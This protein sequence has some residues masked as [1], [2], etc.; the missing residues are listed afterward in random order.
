MQ[1]LNHIAK[2]GQQVFIEPDESTNGP[3]FSAEK[4]TTAIRDMLRGCGL[5]EDTKMM[6]DGQTYVFVS[7]YSLI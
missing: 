5:G 1:A 2:F 6:E 3:R 7:F 4:L